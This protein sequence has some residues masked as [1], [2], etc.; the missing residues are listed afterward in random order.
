MKRALSKVWAGTKI[1]IVLA[2]AGMAAA[3]LLPKLLGMQPLVVLS[4]SMEPSYPVGSLI[5]I[6]DIK[7]KDI[8]E[9]EVLTF[10]KNMGNGETNVTH[11]VVRVD[12]ENSLLYTKGDANNAEDATPSSFEDIVGKPAFTIPYLGYISVYL[13]SQS[14]R[15]VGITVILILLIIFFLPGILMA[16]EKRGEYK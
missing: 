5:Y 1:L 11:R 8:K 6:E 9:G 14:G 2:L 7:G 16:K 4:G 12:L 15:I 10:K 13:G 3:I